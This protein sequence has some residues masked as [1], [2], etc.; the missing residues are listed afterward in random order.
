MK[1]IDE[2]DKKIARLKG[3]R[4]VLF[5]SEAVVNDRNAHNRYVEKG[6]KNFIQPVMW[7]SVDLLSQALLDLENSLPEE[8]D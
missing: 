2:L 4:K 8:E 3:I 7:E 6:S 5:Y 1:T